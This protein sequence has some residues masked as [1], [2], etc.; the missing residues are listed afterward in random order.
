M[1]LLAEREGFPLDAH[2]ECAGTNPHSLSA[3][4]TKWSHV[5]A[6]DPLLLVAIAWRESRFDPNQKGDK[7]GDRFRSCGW[8]QVRTDF[9]GRPTCSQ[10]MDPDF[11][12]GWTA[13]FLT[14]ITRACGGRVCLTR[15]N[16]GDYERLVWRDVDWLRRNL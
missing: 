16:A 5:Y 4:I 10:L 7:L 9:R 6:V 3:I 2:L 8:T 14:E 11:A 1:N 13:N 12:M 15:Y